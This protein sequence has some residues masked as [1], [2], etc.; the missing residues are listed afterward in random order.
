MLNQELAVRPALPRHGT[1]VGDGHCWCPP[2][3]SHAKCT[4][5]ASPRGNPL[6]CSPKGG[7]PFSELWSA[8]DKAKQLFLERRWN[9]TA[10]P[11]ES[12]IAHPPLCVGGH[13]VTYEN[14]FC[15]H[16]CSL[17]VSILKLEKEYLITH[18]GDHKCDRNTAKSLILSEVD[19]P[20]RWLDRTSFLVKNVLSA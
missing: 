15:E 19:I 1:F 3:Q 14:G 2:A 10:A 12:S 18:Y 6:S 16:S 11:I 13:T 8:Q 17:K 7:E 20:H 5:L 4:R 9:M